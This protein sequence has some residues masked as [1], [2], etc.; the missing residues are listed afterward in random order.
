MLAENDLLP[1]NELI[2]E[3]AGGLTREQFVL[4][5]EATVTH[6]L[7]RTGGLRAWHRVLDIG[8][9][10]G[11]IARPLARYLTSGSYDGLDVRREPIEWCRAAYRRHANFRFHHVDVRNS[12]YNPQGTHAAADCALPFRSRSFDRVFLGSVFTHM[13]PADVSR[14]LSE[15]ARVMKRGGKCLATF[16]I[17]DDESASNNAAGTTSPRFAFTF[18]ADGCS[19]EVATIPEAAIAYPERL[20]LDLYA[21]NGLTVTGIDRGAWGRGALVPNM[22]DAVWA[23]RRRWIV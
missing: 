12:R 20:V 18:G 3:H 5:G 11:R 15:I 8:C 9:G 14:Y 2:A 4:G 16:F 21:R 6:A 1:P 23:R 17:L 13:L 10:C 7:I 22:Q 19:I